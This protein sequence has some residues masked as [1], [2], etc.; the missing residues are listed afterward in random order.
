MA[1]RWLIVP[2]DAALERAEVTLTNARP[3]EEAAITKPLLHRQAPRFQTAEVA[4]DARAALAQ[5]WTDPQVDA[6]TLI[7]H[8]RDVGKGR[9]TPHPPLK[10]IA[11]PIQ[12]PVR[13]DQEALRH[14]QQVKAGFVLGTNV[15]TSAWSDAEVM[16]AYPGQAS[17][18]GGWRFRHDPR[19]FGSSWFVKK[20]SR[21]DGLLMVMTLALLVDSVAQRRMRQP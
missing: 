13:P 17:V 3:R 16:A 20:P 5:R 9:P 7:A 19:F 14:H 6:A 11:W 4:Q 21:I 1:Q 8:Q 2:S 12:T 10:A 15:G 18:E